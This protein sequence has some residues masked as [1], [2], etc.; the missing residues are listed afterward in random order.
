MSQY[1]GFNHLEGA[2]GYN[3]DLDDDS[4]SVHSSALTQASNGD[5]H[6]DHSHPH[7]HNH[8]NHSSQ[9]AFQEHGVSHGDGVSSLRFDEL[10]LDSLQA[11]G[12]PHAHGGANEAG[13]AANLYEEDFEGM[14]DDLSRELPAH[15]CR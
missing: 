12:A 5:N 13:Q 11:A 2:S 4:T 14:L 10:S 9:Q 6:H 15:A 3:L 1:S 8:H 7:G